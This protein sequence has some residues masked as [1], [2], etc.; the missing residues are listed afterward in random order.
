VLH[1]SNGRRPG[2]DILDDWGPVRRGR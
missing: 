1:S 2:R